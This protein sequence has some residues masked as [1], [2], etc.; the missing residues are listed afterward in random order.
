VAYTVEQMLV[1]EL[2]ATA[3]VTALV[4]A[5]IYPQAA[6]Q[7]TTADYVTYELVGGT[8]VQDMSGDGGLRRARVSFLCHAAT[9]ANAK[10]AAAAI[11]NA[12]EGFRGTMQG[13]SVGA[14]LLEMEADAGFDD[15]LRMHVVAVDFRMFYQ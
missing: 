6:P 7:G 5:R 10:A 12:L 8:N 2:Q 4:G 13:V 11:Q 15:E 14:L 3:A 9:Y 1:R